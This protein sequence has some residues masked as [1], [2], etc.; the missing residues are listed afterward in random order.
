MVV[1]SVP[2]ASAAGCPRDCS[3]DDEMVSI[4]L[5]EITHANREVVDREHHLDC[6][7]RDY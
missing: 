3:V 2:R 4:V 6:V 1:R 5:G 7:I